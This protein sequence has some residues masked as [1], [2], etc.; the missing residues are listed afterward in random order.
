[1]DV[2][3]RLPSTCRWPMMAMSVLSSACLRMGLLSAPPFYECRGI[4]ARDGAIPCVG[5]DTDR[6]QGE[7]ER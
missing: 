4:G 3:A 2:N 7:A 6:T 1:M 5:Y